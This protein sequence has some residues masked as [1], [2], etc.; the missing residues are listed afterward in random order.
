MKNKR[1]TF[2]CDDQERNLIYRLSVI[3]ER[4]QGDAVRWAV[5]QVY[6]QL[7]DQHKQAHEKS[8]K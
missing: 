5:R 7:T 2:L 4:T 1:F 8:E 6:Q 3:L